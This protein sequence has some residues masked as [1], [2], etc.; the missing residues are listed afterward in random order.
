M[1]KVGLVFI[2]ATFILNFS[3][4]TTKQKDN[5]ETIINVRLADGREFIVQDND[6]V[7]R[8]DLGK[9]YAFENE[10]IV[11]KTYTG[12]F[13]V[14]YEE[15]I[16]YDLDIFSKGTLTLKQLELFEIPF[17]RYNLSE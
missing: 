8:I 7:V 16:F 2:L 11:L 1:K 3:G 12:Q 13:R 9:E 4:C 17:Y 15:E 6:N 10:V 14:V 5:F